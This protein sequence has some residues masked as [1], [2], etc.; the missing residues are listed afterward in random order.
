MIKNLLLGMIFVYQK[1][2]SPS[3]MR[4]CRYYPTCSA[5]AKESIIVHGTF[6]GLLF[7][8]FRFLR[9]NP[10]FKGGYDPVPSLNKNKHIS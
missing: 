7:A 6:K 3:Y 8:I 9:C 10:F 4:R 1:F 5:Y 2:I